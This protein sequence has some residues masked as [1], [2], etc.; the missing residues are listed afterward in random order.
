VTICVLLYFFQEKFIFHP[1]KLDKS[2]N[3]RFDAEFKE[4]AIRTPDG[5]DLNAVLFQADSSRGLIFYL[6]G[7]AGSI[8]SWG[9]IAET[10]T[11]LKYDLF[12]LDYR[13]YGKSDGSIKNTE[14]LFQDIQAAYDTVK[15]IY[16]EEKIV[17]LGYSIGTGLAAKLASTNKPR[18]LILQSP[19]YNLKD[20]M[21]H[22]FPIIPTFTLKY[23][24]ETD[25]YVKGINTPIAIF[26][27][28]RDEVIYYGSSLKLKKLLKKSD[29]LI[30]L[31]GQGHNGMSENQD[32]RIALKKLLN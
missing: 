30:T 19:Y 15:K 24:F 11:Q 25:K 12:M 7:N 18:R 2:Y 8:D 6:H 5:K 20:L 16:P 29:T 4:L 28:D 23:N 13:G 31:M 22:T 26:H 1:D 17:I 3:F 14:Q 32:Y 21:T 10:Y 27:G 9:N